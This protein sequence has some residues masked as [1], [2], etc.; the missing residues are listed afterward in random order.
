MVVALGFWSL[1]IGY[2]LIYTGVQFFT[3][4]GGGGSLAAN[5]GLGK[6]ALTVVPGT[7]AQAASA[8]G[9]VGN[10]AAGVSGPAGTG[11]PSSTELM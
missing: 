8:S 4:P 9:G 11:Y 3:T 5:L 6:S 2:A 1:A 7:S 10:V